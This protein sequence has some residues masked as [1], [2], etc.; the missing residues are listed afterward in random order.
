MPEDEKA[1]LA[2]MAGELLT[3]D[4]PMELVLRPLT[5]MQLTGLVQ[6]ALRHPAI[7]TEHRAVAAHFL[8]IVREYF[9]DCPTMLDVIRRGDDPE[10]DR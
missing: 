10:E 8:T 2:A 9:V 3:K 6:L 5:V 4:A 7:S 1:V